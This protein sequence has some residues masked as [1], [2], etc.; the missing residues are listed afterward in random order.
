MPLFASI[1]LTNLAGG[2]TLAT[3]IFVDVVLMLTQ[4]LREI[5]MAVIAIKEI[6]PVGTSRVGYSL[7]GILGDICNWT[8]RQAPMF[9]GVVT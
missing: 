7:Q 2:R 9:I 5:S 6:K 3:T 8:R 1:S 4:R